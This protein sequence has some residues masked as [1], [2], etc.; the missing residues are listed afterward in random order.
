MSAKQAIRATV[1][2][3]AALAEAPRLDRWRHHMRE[4]P[5]TD[6][7]A[8]DQQAG[9]VLGRIA[10]GRSASILGDG[11]HAIQIGRQTV[12][13]HAASADWRIY[14]PANEPG[15]LGFRPLVAQ[16]IVPLYCLVFDVPRSTAA[17]E[18]E[19]ILDVR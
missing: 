12:H 17:L 7:A 3:L 10:Q 18:I 15:A 1:D 9:R 16:G 2:Y 5:T 14:L 19:V 11:W 8:L 4:L 6:E 13:W